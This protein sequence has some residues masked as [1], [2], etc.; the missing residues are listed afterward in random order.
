MP[1]DNNPLA[2][3]ILCKDLWQSIVDLSFDIAFKLPSCRDN[4]GVRDASGDI[5][6]LHKKLPQ[7][8]EIKIARQRK[9]DDELC[10]HT[11]FFNTDAASSAAGSDRLITVYITQGF[12]SPSL[13]PL[14]ATMRLCTATS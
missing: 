8:V 10:P 9:G 14:A 11:I 12:P 6:R 3:P 2:R 1:W 4:K 5:R 13:A 7:L